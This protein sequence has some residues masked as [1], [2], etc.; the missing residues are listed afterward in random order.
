[1]RSF[2]DYLDVLKVAYKASIYK[3]QCTY[4][5][6]LAKIGFKP[7]RQKSEFTLELNNSL[8]TTKEIYPKNPKVRAKGIL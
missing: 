4:D 1:M 6:H 2:G 7:S 3:H 5:Y 8:A